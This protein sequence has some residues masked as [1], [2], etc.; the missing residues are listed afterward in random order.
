M[1]ISKLFHGLSLQNLGY[2]FSIADFKKLKMEKKT[3]LTMFICSGLTILSCQNNKREDSK[4]KRGDVHSKRGFQNNSQK[5]IDTLAISQK[6]KPNS[7][8]CDLD[9]D[10]LSDTVKIVQNMKNQKYGLKIIFGS[11]KVEY[12][13]MGKEILGQGFDDINWVGVFE[14]ALKNEIYYN[15]VNEEGE[16]ITE[17]NVND[18]DKIRLPNDGVFIHQAE[19]CG[20]GII[21]LKNGKFEWIQQE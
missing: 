8:H 14:V 4:N 18:K 2:N 1:L 3:I 7:I 15:N 17:D 12:L 16:I 11:G 6:H 9:G 10:H 13:G 5:I 19:S 21:Y 20:G